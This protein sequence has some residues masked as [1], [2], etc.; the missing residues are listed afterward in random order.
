MNNAIAFLKTRS[1][2]FFLTLFSNGM[3][4]QERTWPIQYRTRID[5]G[6]PIKEGFIVR[7]NNDTLKGFIKLL[8]ISNYYPVLDTGTNIV[9]DV[10]FND[11]ILMRV[12]DH[13]TEGPFTDFVNLHYKQT[14]WRVLGKKNNVSIC[15][16]ALQM[17]SKTILFTPNKR[18]KIFGVWASFWHGEDNLLIKFMNKR[19][20]TTLK[21]EDFKAT[22]DMIDYILDKENETKATK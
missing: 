12:F 14:L 7:N 10:Y 20:K 8:P 11:I 21:D 15:D 13:S 6:A 9:K 4:A 5:K 19:Y 17:S 22:Q 2:L 16:M 18:I 1:V 3:H